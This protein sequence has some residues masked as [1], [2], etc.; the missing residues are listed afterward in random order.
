MAYLNLDFDYFDHPKTVRLVAIL[1]IGADTLPLRLW[2]YCGKYH[3]KDG[4]MEGYTATEIEALIKWTGPAGAAVD[5]MLK[6][7]FMGQRGD[8]YFVHDWKDHQGHIHALKVRNKKVA[9]KRWANEAKKWSKMSST[10]DTSG[11]PVAYQKRTSGIPQSFPI[12]SNPNHK[13]KELKIV[14]PAD[15]PPEPPQPS[16]STKPKAPSR[17]K[18]MVDYITKSLR[19]RKR[20]DAFQ[21][22]SQEVIILAAKATKRGFQYEGV[23]ALWDLACARLW[24][25]D[26]CAENDRFNAR[27]WAQS[28]HAIKA[29]AGLMEYLCEDPSFKRLRQK[30]VDALN[31]AEGI[32]PGLGGISSAAALLG[33]ANHG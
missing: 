5:A 6:I 32:A 15:H 21:P 16:E 4:V 30:H 9:L 24:Y 1:G 26:R 33:M 14:A 23:M 3:A 10:V 11:T 17:H 27:V 22:T 13:E 29:F 20:D 8:T 2:G 25:P 12:L 7:G 19:E 31:A 18:A 28:G